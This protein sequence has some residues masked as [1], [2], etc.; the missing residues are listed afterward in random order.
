MGQR[1]GRYRAGRVL[2]RVENGQASARYA[3][4]V[5][6]VVRE[7][8]WL[9]LGSCPVRYE[10][11]TGWVET[12]DSGKIVLSSPELLAGKKV[13]V[14]AGYPA[15]PHVR[16]FLDCVKTR[17]RDARSPPTSPASRTSPATR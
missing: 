8:G 11:G 10:G 4:G 12:A 5:K 1:R 3:N 15:T 9:P 13:A 6:L 16:N 7:D 17:A 14:I 2:I